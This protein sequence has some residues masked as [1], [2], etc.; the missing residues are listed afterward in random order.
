ME[1]GLLED[2]RRHGGLNDHI[3]ARV[4]DALHRAAEGG[5]RVVVCT[6]STVGS[7]AEQTNFTFHTM[8]IDR[9]MADA[10]VQCGSRILIA[11]ALADTLMPTRELLKESA[12][13]LRRDIDC[14]DFLI[15]S[16]WRHFESGNLN[17]YHGAIA[18][19]LDD[20]PDGIDVIVLAQASMAPA[21]HLYAGHLPV[22]SSPRIGVDAAL[23]LAQSNIASPIST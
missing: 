9:P 15:E 21:E 18:T 7:A 12:E 23:K 1:P 6:C 16:A 5:A 3:K 13:R 20:A 8:R 14:V 11:A 22:L 19:A 10:A 2:T 4:H 17:A